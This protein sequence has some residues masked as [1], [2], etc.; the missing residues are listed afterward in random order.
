MTVRLVL[1]AAA[2]VILFAGL[3]A[4]VALIAFAR[5]RSL[6]RSERLRNVVAGLL[7]V[8]VAA[9]SLWGVWHTRLNWLS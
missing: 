3:A 2:V 7:I 1:F 5:H 8:A 6:S 9:W 4:G